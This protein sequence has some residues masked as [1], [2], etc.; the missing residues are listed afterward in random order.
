ML[1]KP[2]VYSFSV[3][4]FE[5]DEKKQYL[6]QNAV[7]F[8][9]WQVFTECLP[10]VRLLHRYFPFCCVTVSNLV[11]MSLSCPSVKQRC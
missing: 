4:G 6:S 11:P 5:N 7:Y 2:H 1:A 10:C 8:P 3:V 9:A